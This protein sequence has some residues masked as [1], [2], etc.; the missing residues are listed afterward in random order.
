M[1]GVDVEVAFLELNRLAA[2]IAAS[3]LGV[4]AARSQISDEDDLRMLEWISLSVA[5]LQDLAE[6]GGA[7]S[8]RDRPHRHAIRNCLNAIKGSALLLVEGAPGNGLDPSGA[9]TRDA[10]ALVTH[11]D[12]IITCLDEVKQRASQG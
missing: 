11:S 8:L 5:S 4:L 7:A 3:S 1:T 10:D 9:A 6:Q 12:A 2:C